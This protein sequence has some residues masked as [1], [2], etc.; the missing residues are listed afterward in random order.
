MHHP[1]STYMH[2]YVHNQP[3]IHVPEVEI[4]FSHRSISMHFSRVTDHKL[5]SSTILETFF[6]DVNAKSTWCFLVLSEPS[7]ASCPK[8]VSHVDHHSC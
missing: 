1:A 5:Y 4:T 6:G 2:M 7:N 8:A 3:Y